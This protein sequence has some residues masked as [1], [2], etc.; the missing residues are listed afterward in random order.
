MTALS[1]LRGASAGVGGMIPPLQSLVKYDNATL[2]STIKDRLGAS[3][4]S[5]S[6]AKVG[7]VA[8]TGSKPSFGGIVC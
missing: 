1:H 5:K 4:L 8:F 3:K 2:V 6:P 7:A